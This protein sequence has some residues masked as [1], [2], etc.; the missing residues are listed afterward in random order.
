MAMRGVDHDHVHLGGDQRLGAGMPVLA[1]A[2]R[3]GD[4]QPAELVLV[5]ERMRLRLVH[6]LDGDQA[7]A[8]IGLVHHQQLLDPVPVQQ[9]PRLVAVDVGG[10]P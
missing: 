3:R 7:D 4:A 10:A 9:P 6:V 5:G 8:A 1:H 2:G